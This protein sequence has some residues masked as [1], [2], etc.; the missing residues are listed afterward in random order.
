MGR[1]HS[2]TESWMIRLCYVPLGSVNMSSREQTSVL[3][4]R[5][6]SGKSATPS[7]RVEVSAKAMPTF[8][9]FVLSPSAAGEEATL[10]AITIGA[11]SRSELTNS[12]SSTAKRFPGEAWANGD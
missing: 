3:E 11:E 10:I 4:K 12:R 7:S 9:V 6:L 8:F 2:F 1:I 5:S